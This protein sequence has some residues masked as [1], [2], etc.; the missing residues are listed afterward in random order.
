MNES[1]QNFFSQVKPMFDWMPD[2]VI[3]GGAVILAIIAGIWAHRI[4]VR[5]A[6]RH[7]RNIHP[8]VRSLFDKSAGPAKLAFILLAVW[9]VVP[10]LPVAGLGSVFG[11]LFAVAVIGLMG[12][13]A[14][15]AVEMGA[16]LYLQGLDGKTADDPMS[17]THETQVRVL[18][19]CAD[20][21]IVLITASFALMTFEAGRQMGFSLFATAGLGALVVAFAAYPIIKNLVAGVQ[22]AMTQPFRIGDTVDVE[23]QTGVV[24]DITASSVVM[25]QWDQRRLLMPLHYFMEK[26]IQNLSGEKHEI[27]GT[28]SVHTDYSVPVERVRQKLIEI[29]RSDPRWDGKAASLQVTDVEGGK[30]KLQATV[31]ADTLHKAWNLRCAVREEL[32]AFLQREHRAA[33]LAV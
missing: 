7:I 27:S 1:V 4:F 23:G 21:V 30:L 9:L 18:T 31:S 13:V 29:V 11:T 28:V 17:R 12:W 8:V 14:M 19:R 32:V 16:E 10:M 22:I 33:F 15:N 20:V 26:P 24:E 2:W 3:A 5:V 6:G 25:R